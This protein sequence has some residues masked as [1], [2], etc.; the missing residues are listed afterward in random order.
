VRDRELLSGERIDGGSCFGKVDG[1]EILSR[2][3]SGKDE[4][5]IDVSGQTPLCARHNEYVDTHHAEAER[6]GL[7]RQWSQEVDG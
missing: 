6:L 4:N 7:W 3:Q 1:H 2:A 5:L